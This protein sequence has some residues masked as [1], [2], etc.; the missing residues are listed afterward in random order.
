M[1]NNESLRTA[2]AADAARR[3]AD[4]RTEEYRTMTFVMPDRPADRSRNRQRTPRSV[5]HRGMR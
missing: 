1:T 5:R 4:R 2:A 3:A